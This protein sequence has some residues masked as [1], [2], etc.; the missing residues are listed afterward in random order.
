MGAGKGE[1]GQSPSFLTKEHTLSKLVCALETKH[2][3]VWWQ[4]YKRPGSELSEQ[5]RGGL[6]KGRLTEGLVTM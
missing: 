3:Q 4:D 1:E 5:R 6:S 2:P